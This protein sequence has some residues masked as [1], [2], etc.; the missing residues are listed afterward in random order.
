MIVDGL[1]DVYNKYHMGTPRR[2]SRRNMR[3]RREHRM[4]SRSPR[5]R[6]PTRRRKPADS[7]TRSCRSNRRRRRATD[8]LCNR[9]I[10]QRA[11]PRADALAGLRPAFDKDGTVTAGNASGLNDGAA[12]VMM[13]T[14]RK[15]DELGLRPLA[16]IR[17]LLRPPAWIRSI[18]G[19]GP[20][21]ASQLCLQ[22]RGLDAAGP[23]PAGDQRSFCC[24]GLS[25]STSKWAGTRARSTSMAAPLR[26]VIRSAHRAAASW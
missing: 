9:R 18:M 17:A 23:G 19:M 26:S 10:H 20:V 8:Y 2:I 13:M 7:R 11:G 16:C 14:A 1:W 22:K 21:P 3:S 4:R 15:A 12:A 5:S 6:R 25:P 24:A